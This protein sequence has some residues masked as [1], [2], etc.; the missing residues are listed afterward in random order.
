MRDRFV[1]HGG[2]IAAGL[3]DLKDVEDLRSI[4]LRSVNCAGCHR[5]T[6]GPRPRVSRRRL[7]RG[8]PGLCRTATAITDPPHAGARSGVLRDVPATGGNASRRRVALREWPGS[9]A[10]RARSDD[11]RGRRRDPLQDPDPFLAGFFLAYIGADLT[12]RGGSGEPSRP[13]RP[14]PSSPTARSSSGW[15][16][17]AAGSIGSSSLLSPSSRSRACL[18]S[19]ARPSLSP[20][21]ARRSPPRGRGRLHRR[22]GLAY[23]PGP[24]D[25]PG[26]EEPPRPDPPPEGPQGGDRPLQRRRQARLLGLPLRLG[27]HDRHGRSDGRAGP[28]PESL[29]P[30]RLPGL[31]RRPRRRSRPGR[32]VRP[33]LARLRRPPPAR[34]LPHE[35][36]LARRPDHGRGAEARSP[37][38]IPPSRR[39]AG[40]LS[41]DDS[42]AR[43]RV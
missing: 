13:S 34:R 27:G 43:K 37:A 11:A 26:P 4:G 5:P 32:R 39:G 23:P 17:P 35:P 21:S 6:P 18:S 31:R 42:R 3:R 1:C 24:P 38:R 2:P 10:H 15:T 14:T 36:G 9:R 19:A 16:G 20:P 29:P 41:F 33:D 7:P 40:G 30:G 8:G 12:R 25:R 22:L 28:R